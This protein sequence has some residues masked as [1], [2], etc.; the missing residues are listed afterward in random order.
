VV[1]VCVLGRVAVI[2][3][4][5]EVSLGA[6]REAALLADLLVHRGQVVAASQLVDDIWRGDP[7]R[8]A[9]T[10][11]HTYVNNVRRALE[12]N[13]RRGEASEVLV[14]RRPGYRL[15]IPPDVLDAERFERK[16]GE[17]R[18]ALASG[19]AGH[20]ADALRAALTWWQG[21]AFGTLA[22][23]TYLQS[24]AVRLDQV[25]LVALEER[26]Q[27]DLALGRHDV[28]C[29]E[30]AALVAEHPFH[31]RLWC[32][33]MLALYRSGRQTDALRAAHR[34]RHRLADEL[35]LEPGE[36][37][38]ALEQ[39]ILTHDAELGWRG[40]EER[41]STASTKSR[42]VAGPETAPNMPPTGERASNLPSA[43]TPCVGR[44]ADLTEI[45]DLL[46][47]FRLVTLTGAGGIGKTRLAIEAARSATGQ[48]PDGVWL[49][50]LEALDNDRF[51]PAALAEA[52][53]VM[54]D[55][56]DGPE[57]IAELVS[58][59]MRARHALLVFDNA[60]PLGVG[61]ARVVHL[62]LTTCPHLRI[63]VTS[64]QP[65]DVVGEAVYNV[66][67][68]TLPPDDD[69][70]PS[71]LAAFDA[72]ALFAQRARA[73]RTGFELTGATAGAVAQICRQVDGVPL[74][75]ELAAARI[76]TLG[77]N[78]IA[79]RL[80]E[81]FE[82]GDNEQAT[83][84]PERHRSMQAALEW[85]HQR[86]TPPVQAALRHLAVFRADFDLDA[87]VAMIESW[88]GRPDAATRLS[89][90][91]LVSR[92]VDKSLLTPVAGPGDELR[93]RLLAPVRQYAAE[94]LS[95][96]GEV[97]LARSV[98]RDIFLAR[99]HDLYPLMSGRV[100]RR[101]HADKDNLRAALE[102][103]WAHDDHV[104]AIRLVAAQVVSWVCV[105]DKSE[106]REWME[107]I[108]TTPELAQ[109]PLRARVLIELALYVYDAG[110][111]ESRRVQ[112]LLGE[113]TALGE[114]VGDPIELAACALSRA[115]VELSLGN[116]RQA[117]SLIGVARARYQ[118]LGAP[119]GVGWCHHALG[120]IAIGV[121]R[122]AAAR[123]HF[124][125]ARELAR[126]ADDHGGEWLLPHALAA[127]AP[128]TAL[129]GAHDRALCLADE[130]VAAARAFP[131]GALLAMALTRA[132]E[133]A[134]WSHDDRRT[135]DFLTAL[136]QLLRQL[137]TRRFAADALESAAVL[138][139]RR[140][141]NPEAAAALGAADA[142]RT[143]SGTQGP[144]VRTLAVEVRQSR[145][146]LD[147]A[148]GARAFRA[149]ESRGRASSPEEA[150]TE[151]LS[152]LPSVVHP[153]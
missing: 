53:G 11:L 35:G 50:E 139:E 74:A 43:L 29:G 125:R 107:R 106:C 13:R 15:E 115:E 149:H 140:G 109:H 18:A 38:R 63:L 122:V 121:D 147:K 51:V 118:Q 1:D 20:A 110:E 89:G 17:G 103:S 120:W 94:R 23:E 75:I 25:R 71:D 133:A 19:D 99:C 141:L 67:A 61:V 64:R 76:R 60:E 146:R 3:G 98:H 49:V 72:I 117:R 150:M 128:L 123:A 16:V 46:R 9:T 48:N 92:L 37:V 130:A 28:L 27:A 24:E 152:T 22:S 21:P 70:L 144:G 7:P 102:W 31:E 96:A 95:L 138:F 10:T 69:A 143:A 59:H 77:V 2:H 45:A 14:T 119:A 62:L 5:R 101:H 26:V 8:A 34:L 65:L 56:C 68:L 40:D 41:S 39:A 136:L 86:L 112:E 66:P 85:S 12:P 134:I 44:T 33:W 116:A 137:G 132:T 87:A 78:E 84:V 82:L 93:Y 145:Q 81:H 55:G 80:D 47:S 114:R 54:T 42:P 79:A 32:Q 124:Q 52:L 90:L 142:L 58:C 88:S 97:D 91:A 83:G 131:T 148:L 100:R 151:V 135:E 4:G 129:A 36:A 113:A 30:L 127:L 105:T 104:A 111:R 126:R 108:V 6:T 57:A 153:T 73:A